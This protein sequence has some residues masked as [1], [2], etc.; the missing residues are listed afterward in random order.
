M[1]FTFLQKVGD[2]DVIASGS[3]VLTGT[4]NFKC[5]LSDGDELIN[6]E[7]MFDNDEKDSSER[8]VLELSTPQHGI[9]HLI[10]FRRHISGFAEP[11]NVGTLSN[12]RLY[13]SVVIYSI[14]GERVLNYTF[15][16]ETL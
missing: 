15:M 2:H 8:Y 7:F 14:G 3:V 13:L 11:F 4:G 9:L 6:L 1:T 12:R 5:T 10:N 16:L